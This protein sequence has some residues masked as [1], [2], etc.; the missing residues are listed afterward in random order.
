MLDISKPM[1]LLGLDRIYIVNPEDIQDEGETI[2]LRRS[3]LW[4]VAL[5]HFNKDGSHFEVLGYQLINKI[6]ERDRP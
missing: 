4:M 3:P 2:W 6:E 1:E 5:P